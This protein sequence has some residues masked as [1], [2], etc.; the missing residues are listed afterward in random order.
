M[1]ISAFS[2]KSL[3]FVSAFALVCMAGAAHAGFEWRG[4]VT[5]PVAPVQAMP[6]AP[7]PDA[8]L[9][10]VIM[11]DQKAK[12]PSAPHMPAE[13]VAP[14]EAA[15]VAQ[16]SDMPA[17]EP[18]LAEPMLHDDEMTAPAP[19]TSGAPASIA[20]W[21]RAP[22]APLPE[23]AATPVEEVASEEVVSGFGEGMPLV[24]ALQQVVPA[25]Y[26]FA[27]AQGVN[28]GASVSWQGGKPW[29]GVLS[30]M[31][32][33]QGLGYRLQGGNVV[34][35]GYYAPEENAP[36]RKLL[37]PAAATALPVPAADSYAAE[38]ENAPVSIRR[39]KPSSLL[40]RMK[41]S[42][43]GSDDAGSVTTANAVAPEA[44][45][46]Q[47]PVQI[48][49]PVVAPAV[50]DAPVMAAPDMSAPTWAGA[51]GQTVRDVLKNWSDVAG[52]ELY[53][54][55]DYDYRLQEDAA[56]AGTY[57]EAVAKLLERFA[58]VRPQPYGQLHQGAQGGPR[59][60]VVKSYDLSN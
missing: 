36:E 9:S 47:A 40:D 48:A 50:V 53:W 55:I 20:S 8:D 6:Q 26:Q 33:A 7:A 10:P 11:W 24:I 45:A 41:Q 4:P 60:L 59:V 46:P 56:F 19:A 5:P 34:M 37:L 21:T 23:M 27:F 51:R 15:P 42:F 35:I 13:K 22:A 57:D 31:L 43:A 49:A 29:R 18:A 52:V 25:G 17:S 30:D 1:F 14:V 2:K 44:A 58:A 32:A 28:P 38:K 12:M 16:S 3:G 39:Q 54:T